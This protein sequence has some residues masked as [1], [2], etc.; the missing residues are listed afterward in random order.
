[1]TA[2]FHRGELAVQ[3]RAGEA[4]IA[5]RVAR[6]V[7]DEIP[8]AAAAYLA[9]QAFVVVASTDA[10][11]HPDASL[12]SGAPGFVRVTGPRTLVIDR[13]P[14]SADPLV[15]ALERAATPIGLLAIEPAT[16]RRVRINGTASREGDRIVVTTEQVFANCPKYI[17]V[18]EPT[19]LAAP[20]L[21]R[22]EDAPVLGAGDRALIEAA[23]AFFIA[24]TDGD[25]HVD[26]SHRGGAPGFVTVGRDG[27]LA[28]PD[29]AGNSMFMTLGN[30]EVD[31]RVALLFVDWATGD[32]L[33]LR[34]N[35]T[36]DW[37]R[38]RA[39]TLP[40]ARRVVDVAVAHV[41]RFP[42]ASPLRWR[43]EELS[44]FNP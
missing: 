3:R 11:G 41:S 23:D 20:T 43:L 19:A 34:G 9:A 24:S 6:S 2:S 7:Q 21:D 16:R 31:P 5:A 37:S 4:E 10:G 26:A 28:F 38:E 39:A 18:R 22:R 27:T 29:Y 12:L 15:A 40:G 32:V 14:A 30:L 33:E 42:R 25:G 44:P 35:A 8:A 1:M 13:I 17:A 36:I